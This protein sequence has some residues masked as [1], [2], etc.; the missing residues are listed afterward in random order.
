VTIARLVALGRARPAV[1]RG[2]AKI[3]ESLLPQLAGDLL[4]H[5]AVE[6][7]VLY[8][9]ACEALHEEAWMGTS[10]G[11]N[12]QA[13]HSLERVL[14]TPF[15]GEEFTL[16]I[17]ELRNLVELHAEEQEELFFPQLVRVFDEDR[18]R[19]IALSMLSL[20]HAKVEAGYAHESAAR[21]G[22]G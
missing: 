10:R 20:Y 9:A 8:P 19:S 1:E 18:V 13:R 22:K 12:V 4:A 5:L 3:R 17:G 2:S 6:E 7:Q 16:A 14:D 11:Y 15:D 21:L